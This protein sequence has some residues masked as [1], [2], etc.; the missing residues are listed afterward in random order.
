LSQRR[1][2]LPWWHCHH[3]WERA[4]NIYGRD[5]F[6]GKQDGWSGSAEAIV[7]LLLGL[8][9]ARS[10]VDFGCGTGNWLAEF[11]RHGVG[12]YLGVDG[13]HVPR[14]MLRIPPERF[15]AADFGRLERLERRFDI[16]CCLEFA[17][18]L[19]AERAAPLVAL[20]VASAPVVL[21]SAAVPSQGGLGHVNERRQSYWAG[22]FARHGYVPVDCIRPAI[23]GAAG[24]DWYYAQN[25]LVYCTPDRTPAGQEPVRFPL[26]LDLLDDRLLTPLVR[27]PDSIR[28]AVRALG[29]DLAALARALARRAGPTR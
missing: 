18:H 17:E 6:A 11:A 29:R 24:I 5:Y 19:P 25:A 12:D 7:P 26:Y 23:Y 14:D 1:L 21:F 3:A 13:A 16:A 10:V 27:G 9:P 4:T 20:L 22:L 15:L 2:P 8:F 28:S